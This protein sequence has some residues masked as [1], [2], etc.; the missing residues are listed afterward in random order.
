MVW[1]ARLERIGI[2]PEFILQTIAALQL[3]SLFSLVISTLFFR[4]V[5]DKEQNTVTLPVLGTFEITPIRMS[6]LKTFIVLFFIWW[7]TPEFMEYTSAT[8]SIES[9]MM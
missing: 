6:L 2:S 1:S 9:M 5:A 7:V 8:E 3:E 4:F